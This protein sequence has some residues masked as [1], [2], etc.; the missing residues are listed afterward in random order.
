VCR[1]A[2]GAAFRTAWL[3]TRWEYDFTDR[4]RDFAAALAGQLAIA[5]EHTRLY[6]QIEVKQPSY[7]MSNEL[8]GD[9]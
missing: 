2:L 7:A 4:E 6:E 9:F 3:F 5:I 1:Y 8:K